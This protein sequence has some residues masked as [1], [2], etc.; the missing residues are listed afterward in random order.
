MKQKFSRF[1]RLTSHR[2][3]RKIYQDGK[4]LLGNRILVHYRFGQ[5][6]QPRL[7]ITISRKWGKA[8]KRNRFKR[9]V[10]DAYR[11]IYPKLADYLELNIHPRPFFEQLSSKEVE[12]ELNRL[13]KK[14]GD[15]T[16]SQSRKSCLHN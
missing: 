8:C 1:Q 11:Q 5:T 16:Q 13:V 10:R 3:F 12:E 7:G 9:L 2:D 14:I 15:K 4:R 6:V